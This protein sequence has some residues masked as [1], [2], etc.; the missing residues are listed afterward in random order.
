MKLTRLCPAK[1]NLFL[2]VNGKRP[3]G[4]HELTT[5]FAKINWTDQVTLEVE[6]APHTHLS[7]EITGPLGSHIPA[8]PGNL[9]WKAASAFLDHYALTARIHILLEK[10]LPTGAGLGG[11]SSDAGGVL[12]L[13][14]QFFNKNPLELIDLAARLGA[15]VPLFLYPD[16]FL[17]GEGIG[18]K[19]TPIPAAKQLPYV[20]L[21]YPQVA[22]ST[23]EVF[24]RLK[25][26]EPKEILTNLSK[27]DRLTSVVKNG[28]SLEQWKPLLFNRLEDFVL[29]FV[30]AVN[31]ALGHLRQTSESICMMSGSGSTV[32]SLVGTSKDAQ[33]LA[34]RLQHTK[35]LII[36]TAFWGGPTNADYGNQCPSNP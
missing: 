2:E 12:L 4:Y 11:G 22:V 14:C 23:R 6:P 21:V 8:T 26:P 7:L 1:I 31:E 24:A 3:N 29:P 33:E 34:A 32:F 16:T 17:K 30:P 9:V 35:A 19:L 27:L 36:S 18:E 5:L 13:L 28:S 25:L 10:H 15:D 20:V